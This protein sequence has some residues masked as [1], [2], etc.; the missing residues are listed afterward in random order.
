MDFTDSA[1]IAY[2]CGICKS[3]I[4]IRTFFGC[5]ASYPDQ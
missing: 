2:Y 4:P 3:N 5:C 1:S